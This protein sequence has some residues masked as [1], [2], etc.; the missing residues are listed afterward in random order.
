[1]RIEQLYPFPD[2][3]CRK[4]LEPYQACERNCLVSGRTTKSRRM[5][6]LATLILVVCLV[7]GKSLRYAGSPSAA[8]P[9]VGYHSVHEK[10]QEE[11][12]AQALNI[13]PSTK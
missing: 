7:K 3:E 6:N 4:M 5:D 11:L 13:K 1:M 9:A 12:V 8:S 10:E 2:D